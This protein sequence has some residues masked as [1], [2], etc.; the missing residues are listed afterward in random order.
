MSKAIFEYEMDT[1][2]LTAKEAAIVKSHC[3]GDSDQEIAHDHGIS[4]S[5]LK[6]HRKN[7]LEKKNV[8]RIKQLISRKELKKK[9][10]FSL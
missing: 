8:F 6:T 9:Y 10:N 4:I 3:H 5:T 1:K 7:I 2:G